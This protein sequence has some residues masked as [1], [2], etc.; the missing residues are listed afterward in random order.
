M[1]ERTKSS[2]TV[3]CKYW[4]PENIFNTAST[5]PCTFITFREMQQFVSTDLTLE[6]NSYFCPIRLQEVFQSSS[7]V[8]SQLQT[9]LVKHSV[10]QSWYYREYS[11]LQC[12]QVIH[13]Q[14]DIPLKESYP[15]SMAQNHTLL[16]KSKVSEDSMYKA[17]QD[18]FVVCGAKTNRN[19]Y[20]T[21]VPNQRSS[22]LN[23]VQLRGS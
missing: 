5:S 11:W 19:K 1:L 13:K 22:W 16:E 20:C 14:S 21:R 17:Q 12:F 4:L 18:M 6:H 3:L 9:Y 15:S 23:T 7:Q 2:Q 8:Q 10:Q